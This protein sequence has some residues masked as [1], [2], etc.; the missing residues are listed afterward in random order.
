VDKLKALHDQ[1]LSESKKACE[2]LFK[3]AG[4]LGIA[5]KTITERLVLGAFDAGYHAG[6]ASTAAWCE[7]R[8]RAHDQNWVA[9]DII[10]EKGT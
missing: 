1:A 2:E 9:T 10:G 4:H 8:A 6:R 7:E 5:V 3:I